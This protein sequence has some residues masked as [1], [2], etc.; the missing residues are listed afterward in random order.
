MVCF[1][2]FSWGPAIRRLQSDFTGAYLGGIYE[3]AVPVKTLP[4]APVSRSLISVWFV[5][6]L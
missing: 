5:C 6:L 4:P 3:E 1:P 2:G